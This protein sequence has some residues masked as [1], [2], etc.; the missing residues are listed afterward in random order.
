MKI[1]DALY[2]KLSKK[3]LLKSRTHSNA[4]RFSTPSSKHNNSKSKFVQISL[5]S[6]RP[7]ML[8]NQRHNYEV[9]QRTSKREQVSVDHDIG[10]K[11]DK[12]GGSPRKHIGM[13]NI[14]HSIK[15]PDCAIQKVQC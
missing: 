7:A 2:E 13:L 6:G 12:Y 15:K 3:L 9:E 1:Y 14:S 11:M 10:E 4:S 8:P 5:Y